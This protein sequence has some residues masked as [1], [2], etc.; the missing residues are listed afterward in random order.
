MKNFFPAWVLLFFLSAVALGQNQTLIVG[1]ERAGPYTIGSP[2]AQVQ[3]R[4]GPP[5]SQ[6]PTSGDPGTTFRS[7]KQHQLAFL[8]NPEQKIIGI[9]VA[10]KDW[11]TAQGLGVG[12]P[13][14]AFQELFGKGLKRGSGQLA[15][16]EAGLAITFRGGLVEMIY[17]V[18]IDDVDKIKGDHLLVGGSRAGQL[19]LGQSDTDM[20]ALLGR[21]SQKSGPQDNIWTYPDQGIRLGFIEGRLHLVGVT[22]GDWVTPSGLKVGRPFSDM[23]RELGNDYRI[24]QSS[25]FYDKWGIGARLQGEQIVELLI[26]NPR[27]AG[28]QG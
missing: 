22:S 26:F 21:P 25:V 10:R 28:R 15:F 11:K 19:R 7:Y 24:D 27:Q 4:L 12:S 13:V 18:K 9:T 2:F 20:Q 6:Q 23:K 8:V 17:V 1:G 5:S 3:S 16:P 14:L